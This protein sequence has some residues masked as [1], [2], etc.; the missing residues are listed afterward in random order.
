MKY[1]DV[2]RLR[3][4]DGVWLRLKFW[5]RSVPRPRKPVITNFSHFSDYD[6]RDIGLPEEV[7]YVDW[8]ALKA[9]GW[10]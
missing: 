7:R 10:R 6:R 3:G 1:E 8:R 2:R 5:L 4:V 9:N